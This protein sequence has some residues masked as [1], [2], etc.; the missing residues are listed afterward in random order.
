M[1]YRR[2][3]V[4]FLVALLG[5]STLSGNAQTPTTS[6]IPAE[7]ELV[8]LQASVWRVYMP[9]GTFTGTGIITLDEATPASPVAEMPHLRSIDVVV[10][11][12]DTAEHAASAFERISAGAEGSVAGVFSD[13][14][15]EVTS[16]ALS[17]IGSQAMLVRVD[18]VGEDSDVWMEYVIVQRGQYVFFVGA[19]GSV[20]VN[21]PGSDDVDM[22]LPT[23]ELAAEIAAHGE[24]SSDESTF[25]DDGSSTGGL[26]EFMPPVDDPLLRGLVPIRDTVLYPNPRA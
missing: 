17:D 11:E 12:F 16:E 3:R 14:T 4:M 9:T 2:I 10:R 22:S 21:T 15:Q 7:D 26:W 8:G 18:H 5:G 1:I 24:P 20:F 6:T 13:G 19:D 23:V 25:S